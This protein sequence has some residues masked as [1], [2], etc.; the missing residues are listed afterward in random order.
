MIPSL[1]IIVTEA[2][3]RSP[4]ITLLGRVDT[5]ILRSKDSS[6]SNITSS[7]I[8]TENGTLVVS[9]GNVTING[10]EL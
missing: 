6:I 9:A 7:V 10:P 5:S 1:S 8:G 3:P 4:T 2:W